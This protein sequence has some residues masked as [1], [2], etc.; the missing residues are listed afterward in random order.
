MSAPRLR[1]VLVGVTVGVV[2]VAIAVTAALLTL[3]RAL[4]AHV[5]TLATTVE[6]LRVSA[7]AQAALR[8]H[9]IATSA[10]E[11]EAAAIRLMAA[12]D[13]AEQQ[14]DTEIE[15]AALAAAKADAEAYLDA[16]ARGAPAADITDLRVA[17]TDALHELVAAEAD[18][19]RE[20]R[21]ASAELDQIATGL[22]IAAVAL[23]VIAAA[24]FLWWVR[25]RAFD[26]LLALGGAMERYGRG[27]PASRAHEAG[28]EELRE[29]ARQFNAMADALDEHRRAR[30]AF[31]GGVAHDLRTPLNA[32]AL[33]L[34]LVGV[35]RPGSDAAKESIERAQRQVTRLDRMVTD[36]LDTTRIE[37]GQLEMRFADADVRALVAGVVESFQGGSP[38]HRLVAALPDRPLTARCD[39]GRI[40]QVV[41][42]LITNAI[43]YSPDG[44]TID[45]SATRRGERIE[46]AVRDPG[47]GIP[48]DELEHVFAPFRRV[49]ATADIAAGAGLGLFVVRRIVEAHGGEIHVESA[50][51][52]GSTFRVSLPT[53]A[54]RE[55]AL[56]RAQPYTPSPPP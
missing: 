40:E 10:V 56:P 17:I 35:A 52:A 46:V 51:G 27:A 34:D 18:V 54:T 48:A 20:A 23:L 2:A 7:D 21:S 8:D 12:L 13:R 39:P 25:S 26:P 32:L 15:M 37:A 55:S 19:A 29:M 6:N 30:L 3:T 9:R 36:L 41:G 53:S 28:A 11:R 47:V 1:T 16:T 31:L 22:A 42:N 50:P 45:V 4:D 44:G 49:A 33:S 38:R 43:K 14:L 5:D 24:V